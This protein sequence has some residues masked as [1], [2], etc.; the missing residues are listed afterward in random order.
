M[1]HVLLQFVNQLVSSLVTGA[2]DAV[3]PDDIA[4]Q[5][6]GHADGRGLGDGGMADQRALDLGRAQPVAADLDHVVDAADHPDVAVLVHTRR[7]AGQ[8]VA[9]FLETLPVLADVA[10]RVAVNRAR[11]AGPGAFD[12]QVA[13][14]VGRHRLAILIYDFNLDAGEG[15][16]G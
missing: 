3:D 16:S 13:V 8:I 14:F 7:V 4:A 15:A 2:Q 1:A 12:D 6:V 11:H 10:L 9:L 5:L